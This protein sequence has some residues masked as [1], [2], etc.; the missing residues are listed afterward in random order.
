[1]NGPTFPRLPAPRSQDQRL[2]PVRPS[3]VGR[4]NRTGPAQTGK[5]PEFA[6]LTMRQVWFE[7]RRPVT[8]SAAIGGQAFSNV[9]LPG[10]LRVNGNSRTAGLNPAAP[11]T[12]GGPS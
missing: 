6:Y 11:A 10:S 8:A 7:P 4:A 1:M 5:R 3:Q 9:V 2:I 12:C